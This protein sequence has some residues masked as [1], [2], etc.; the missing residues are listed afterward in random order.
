MCTLPN[1]ILASDLE[2]HLLYALLR[3]SLNPSNHRW[4]NQ[5]NRSIRYYDSLAAIRHGIA[6]TGIPQTGDWLMLGIRTNVL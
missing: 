1:R 2:Q 3:V 5:M 4:L 6:S